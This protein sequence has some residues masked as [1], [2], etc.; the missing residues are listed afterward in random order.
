MLGGGP[1]GM[2]GGLGLLNN[3][4]FLQ[5]NRSLKASL[6][7]VLV[8]RDYQNVRLFTRCLRFFMIKYC[9]V[10]LE[11]NTLPNKWVN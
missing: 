11:K 8:R 1:G 2:V 6:L 3:R 9:N 4:M 5:M 10:Q 7:V